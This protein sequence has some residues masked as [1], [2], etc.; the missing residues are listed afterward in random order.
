L[1]NWAWLGGVTWTSDDAGTSLGIT[2]TAGKRSESSNDN[3]AMYSIVGKHNFTDKL[4]FIMQHDH[5]FADNVWTPNGLASGAEG[6]RED[7]EWYGLNNY[8]IYDV[9]DK[10]SAGLRAEWFRDHNGMRVWG[11]GRCYAASANQGD[12]FACSGD[13]A[14]NYPNANMGSNYYA[15]TAG[16][17]YKP[18]KWL[19]LRPNLRYDITDRA[20]AFDSGNSR[21]QFLVTAD[22]VVTF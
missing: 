3:W 21:S 20:Q 16:M 22:V 14:A 5:G 2:S 12:N 19:N 17:S 11:P 15:I 13:Y 10:V 7:A 1:G 4:H 8:L 9:N 18:A 6:G